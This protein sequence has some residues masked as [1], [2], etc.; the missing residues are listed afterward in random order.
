MGEEPYLPTTV[1][2]VVGKIPKI[3]KPPLVELSPDMGKAV[4]SL[5][6]NQQRFLCAARFRLRQQLL[7]P[8]LVQEPFLVRPEPAVAAVPRAI[9][10]EHKGQGPCVGDRSIGIPPWFVNGFQQQL[11]SP[12]NPRWP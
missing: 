9:M 12:K 5:S 4:R 8:R 2:H 7:Q 11:L 10:G 1:S 6:R 3:G